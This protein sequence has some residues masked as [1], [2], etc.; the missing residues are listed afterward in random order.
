MQSFLQKTWTVLVT[1]PTFLALPGASCK[2]CTIFKSQCIYHEST[3]WG[4]Y[5]YVFYWRH[6]HLFITR[7]FRIEQVKATTGVRQRLFKSS[8]RTKSKWKWVWSINRALWNSNFFSVAVQRI[9]FQFTRIF[10]H[11][12][13]NEDIKYGHNI[14]TNTPSSQGRLLNGSECK[15]ILRQVRPNLFCQVLRNL[16]KAVCGLQSLIFR[17]RHQ[18]SLQLWWMMQT[19]ILIFSS[20]KKPPITGEMC[21]LEW[22]NE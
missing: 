9:I 17:R 15:F 2:K 20:W 3:N 14:V 11:G 5:L 7:I 13:I 19:G 12:W 10:F 4:H 18:K 1:D 16:H 8:E 22:M 6:N 21:S